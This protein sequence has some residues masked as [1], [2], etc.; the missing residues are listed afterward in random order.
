VLPYLLFPNHL[1]AAAFA[2]MIATVLLIVLFFNYYIA[3]TKEEPF[4]RRFG[5]MAI[6]SLSVAAIS[7]VIGIIAKNL[8]GIET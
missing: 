5:E 6:I 7:F 4:L 2:C 3:V 1:Y 8:L